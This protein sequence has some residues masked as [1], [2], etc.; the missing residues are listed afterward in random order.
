MHFLVSRPESIKLML[1]QDKEN[2][3]I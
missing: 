2:F 1:D 3:S